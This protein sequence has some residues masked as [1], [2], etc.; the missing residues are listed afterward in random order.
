V[1]QFRSGPAP[2]GGG[3]GVCQKCGWKYD[4]NDLKREWT[5][6]RVCTTCWDPRPPQLSAPSVKPEGLARQDA[7]PEPTFAEAASESYTWGTIAASSTATT[8]VTIA[9]AAVGDGK[10]YTPYMANGWSG[11]LA[12]AA[13]TA[14]NTVTVTVRNTTAQAITLASDTLTVTQVS[15]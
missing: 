7:S 9:G 10:E 2:K 6:L 12:S 14:P 15:L 5:N 1:T 13:P 3:W 8:A 4:L 11:L